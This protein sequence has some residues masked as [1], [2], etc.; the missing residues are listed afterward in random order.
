M[1]PH[2][3][4]IPQELLNKAVEEGAKKALASIGLDD[5]WAYKDIKEV[6]SLLKAWREAKRTVWQSVLHWVITAVIACIAFKV[7]YHGELR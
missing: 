3:N 7:G 5:K 4:H 1:L 2:S 6:R